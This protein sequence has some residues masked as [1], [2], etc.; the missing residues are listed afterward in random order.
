[1]KSLTVQIP[2]PCTERWDAMQ[3]TEQG[4]FCAGCQKTV[5]DYTNLSDRELVRRLNQASGE[6]CGRLGA[7]QVDR[8]LVIPN[9]E[10]T[11]RQRWL[12]VLT[13][14]LLSWQTAQ[15]QVKTSDPARTVLAIPDR[16]IESLSNGRITPAPDTNRVITGRVVL[17][18]SSGAIIP[19]SN[20][21][22]SVQLATVWQTQ[23]DSTG[24]FRLLVPA[25]M[26]NTPV[27]I[28]VVAPNY[29]QSRKT[30]NTIATSAPIYVQ[31]KKIINAVTASTP[32]VVGDIVVFEPQPQRVISGGGLTIIRQPSRWERFKRKLL[33]KSG[34]E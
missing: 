12:G 15:A 17:N 13:M 28:R 1:M 14:G 2:R 33:P 23:T 30:I 7:D 5:V 31:G 24:T 16:P 29:I 4:R 27:T 25:E 3:P 20:A 21:I 26:S 9:Q 6:I 19:V 32:I 18:D 10:I 34:N 8:P 22:V 11:R